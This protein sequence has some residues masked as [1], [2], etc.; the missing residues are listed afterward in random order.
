MLRGNP[1]DLPGELFAAPEHFG[2][3][4]GLFIWQSLWPLFGLNLVLALVSAAAVALGLLLGI[5]PLLVLTAVV[6]Y[7]A[8]SML[9]AAVAGQ[10][11]SRRGNAWSH[12]GGALRGQGL[13]SAGVGLFLNAFLYSYLT[14]GGLAASPAAGLGLR[15]VWVGQSIFLV[16]LAA[17]AL[18]AFPLRAIHNQSLRL[19]V[20]NGLLLAVSAPGATAA[21]LGAIGL[22]V[23]AFYWLDLGAATFAP[24]LLACLLVANCLLQ[25][26]TKTRAEHG[27]GRIDG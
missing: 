12:A 5:G 13:A 3:E 7:P 22:V 16:V 10:A 21:M 18:Y 27:K 19:A 20:R 1:P 24:L 2:R 14:A 11:L 6:I 17:V 26:H 9:L 4:V 25:I 8:W 15:A 23:L